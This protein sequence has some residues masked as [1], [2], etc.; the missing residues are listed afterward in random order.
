MLQEEEF[1]ETM[2]VKAQVS[3]LPEWGAGCSACPLGV[4][5]QWQL[6]AQG[7]GQ[8]SPWKAGSSLSHPAWGRGVCPL[9]ADFIL[10]LYFIMKWG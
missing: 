8:A 1:G 7:Q 5:P 3:N 10:E 6:S 2:F 4:Q 9:A